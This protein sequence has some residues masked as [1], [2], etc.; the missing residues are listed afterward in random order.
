ML[1]LLAA[2]SAHAEDVVVNSALE[3]AAIY[4]NGVETGLATPATVKAPFGRVQVSIEKGCQRGEA[5]VDVPRGGT[6]KVS[7][8]AQETP[9]WVVVNVRPDDAVLELDGRAFPGVP[10]VPVEVSCGRHS[11]RAAREGFIPAIVTVDAGPGREEATT[12]SLVPLASGTV[13]VRV[14]PTDATIW[15]DGRPLG[16]GAVSLP[17]VYE[18]VHQVG[19]RLD[20]YADG[21]ASVDVKGGDHLVYEVTLEKGTKGRS[22]VEL[23]RGAAVV[24]REGPSAPPPAR[25]DRSAPVNRPAPGGA[26]LPRVLLGTAGAGAVFTGWATYHTSVAYEAYKERA[27]AATTP[28]LGEAADRFYDLNVV[29]RRRMIWAGAAGTAVLAVAG[30]VTV[31]MDAGPLT[32]SALPGGVT[33]QGSF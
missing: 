22:R 2:L 31:S 32:L 28:E 4:V 26:T 5:L 33:L 16:V 8:F 27:A 14:R 6:A 12:L 23:V 10:G 24:A 20:G 19:A 9:G 30:V 11:L 17:T 15:V 1:P 7:V 29:P 25:R 13:E 18:G 3:G 21:I